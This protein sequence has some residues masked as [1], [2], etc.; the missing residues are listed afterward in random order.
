MSLRQ[1][2]SHNLQ[3]LSIQRKSH[4]EVARAIGVNRQQYNNYLYGKNLPNETIIERMCNYFGIE[5]A[6]LFRSPAAGAVQPSPDIERLAP[7]QQLVQAQALENKNNFKPGWYHI[8]FRSPKQP[9][10]YTIF[11]MEARRRDGGLEFRRFSH[12][13]VADSVTRYISFHKGIVLEAREMVYLLSVDI[14]DAGSPSLLVAKP[15]VSK[16]ISYTGHSLV[17]NAALLQIL[18]FAIVP[19]REEPARARHFSAARYYDPGQ[20]T[21]LPEVAAAL[22]AVQMA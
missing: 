10:S 17:R 14:F 20:Y 8:V 4:A 5:L 11:A 7:F 3:R 9:Y 13:G 16:M 21:V 2:F 22:D 18:P 1:L 19:V 6:E 12:I 15:L